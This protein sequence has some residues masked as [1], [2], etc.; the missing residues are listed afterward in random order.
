MSVTSYITVSRMF[1]HNPEI[2]GEDINCYPRASS[3]GLK[4]IHTLIPSDGEEE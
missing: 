1:H 4:P 3:P 2:D